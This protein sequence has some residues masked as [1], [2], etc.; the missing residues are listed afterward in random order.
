MCDPS[1]LPHWPI[2]MNVGMPAAF[3]DS[4]PKLCATRKAEYL[5]RWAKEAVSLTP[6]DNQSNGCV[7]PTRDTE[8]REV[9]SVPIMVNGKQQSV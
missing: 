7:R 9:L 5:E 8:D 3:F 2:A 6:C 1:T 4:E